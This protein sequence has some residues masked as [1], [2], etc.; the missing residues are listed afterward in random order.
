ALMQRNPP[1]AHLAWCNWAV[2]G[3]PYYP[4][5][6]IYGG[7]QSLPAWALLACGESYQTPWM[8]KR[9]NWVMADDTAITYDRSMRLQT[10]RFLPRKGW[11][12]WVRR[13]RD[14]LIAS[15]TTEGNFPERWTGA[16]PQDPFS[17]NA[18]GQYGVMGLQASEQLGQE[19]D[20]N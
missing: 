16:P 10:L 1:D 8:Q 14:G 18:N 17:E 11:E 12:D 19:V 7:Q 6:L 9:V 3:I 2:Q 13:D 4:W 5:H 15:I 20:V